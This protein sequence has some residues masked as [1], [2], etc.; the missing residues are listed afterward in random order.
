[1]DYATPEIKTDVKIKV[2]HRLRS[3][4]LLLIS[5]HKAK[6]YDDDKPKKKSFKINVADTGAAN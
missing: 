3:D 6:D 4:K 1:M 2:R 5:H